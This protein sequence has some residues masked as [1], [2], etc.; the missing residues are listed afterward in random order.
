MFPPYSSLQHPSRVWEQ[1]QVS[2]A[3]SEGLQQNPL[4]ETPTQSSESDVAASSRGFSRDLERGRCS[5]NAG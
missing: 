4:E 1:S 3:S 2:P 5:I